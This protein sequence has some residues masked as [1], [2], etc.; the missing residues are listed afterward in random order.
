MNGELE[1]NADG[2]PSPRDG[3]AQVRTGAA[4]R[5]AIQRGEFAPGQR[6]VE[7]DLMERFGATRAGVRLALADLAGEGLVERLQNKGARVRVVT[8][9]TAVEIT[10]CRMVL[11]GL[12]A[13]KAAERV[14]DADRAELRGL[15]EQMRSA[16]RD[17]DL[18]GY[19]DL[20][21]QLHRRIRQM[22]AQHTAI[23]TIERLRGQVVRHQFQLALRPGRPARSLEEHARIAEAVISGDCAAAEAAM[24]AH[25]AS[26]IDALR[27]TA[28]GQPGKIEP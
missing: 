13:A 25:L 10:E 18:L 22:S 19:S 28:A 21:H 20:N 16:V 6:L 7:S 2:S 3:V 17:G 26:V 15:V 9:G 11:E 14:T 24:R 23:A 12:C 5:D 8:P 27:E 4:L 1:V